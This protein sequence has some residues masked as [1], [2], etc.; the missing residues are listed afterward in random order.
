[1]FEAGLHDLLELTARNLQFRHNPLSSAWIV[2]DDKQVST[3]A[4]QPLFAPDPSAAID[5]PLEKGLE[6]QLRPDIFVIE[7]FDPIFGMLVEELP[8]G[9]E[10]F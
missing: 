10:Q 5:D 1:M 2:P 8:E 9:G 3:F 7:A 4:P 6:Q